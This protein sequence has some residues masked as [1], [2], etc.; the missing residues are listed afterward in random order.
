[1]SKKQTAWLLGGGLK[2]AVRMIT[3]AQYISAEELF[4]QLKSGGEVRDPASAYA[5]VVWAYRCVNLRALIIGNLPWRIVDQRG[6]EVEGWPLAQELDDLL[7]RV[8]F[9]LCLWGASYLLKQNDGLALKGLRWQNPLTMRPLI[10]ARGGLI[11]FEQRLREEGGA[12]T[13]AR[14][15]P[16]Q[17]IYHR[18]ENPA[19]D[20]GPGVSPLQVALSAAGL[21][22]NANVYAEKFFEHGAIPAVVLTTEEDL[23]EGDREEARN[24]WRRT[25]GG[26]KKSWETGIFGRGLKPMVV[27]S[28]VK[29]LVLSSLYQ[30]MRSQICVAF[31][32]PQTLLEDAA[33]FA[34]AREHKLELYQETIFP[35]GRLI[36]KGLNRQLFDALGLTFE[37]AEEQVEAVQ[38]DEATKA[39]AI[40]GLYDKGIITLNE[41]RE[42]LGYEP[43]AE[44]EQEAK[45]EPPPA[46]E[47]SVE[48]EADAAPLPKAAYQELARW[49]R[50]AARGEGHFVSDV[51]PAWL[52]SAIRARLLHPLL[53]DH[54]IEPALRRFDAEGARKK[55]TKKVAAALSSH[56]DD[57]ILGALGGAMP[58]AALG[59]LGVSLT[60]T[61]TEGLLMI[62]LDLLLE[63]ATETGVGID[64]DKE[65]IDAAK[66]AADY[67]YEQVKDVVDTERRLLQ[68]VISR[69]TDG[70]IDQEA[71]ELLL[72]PSFGEVRAALIATSEATRAM[73]HAT[74]QYKEEL[75][76]RGPSPVVR[77]LT[78]EDEKVCDLCGP[79]D[80]LPEEKWRDQYPD[81]PPAHPGCRCRTVVELKR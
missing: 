66:W 56:A 38:Q 48:E 29:D 6:N 62:A 49:R 71:A 17:V 75:R 26:V 16:G 73:S 1:M 65:M 64:Y 81:G 41:A 33:N 13:V 27:G 18:L 9:A 54:A 45:E 8:E 40:M 78:E 50:K 24:W 34:T 58:E 69:L 10:E 55:L 68:D 21:A 70:Q 3:E 7:G 12:E 23:L 19:D 51:I 53:R 42:Q 22:R 39:T 20:L 43:L 60:S 63:L 5:A 46:E 2:R 61:L 80:H 79:L 28:P 77:W 4:A 11:G 25:F 57:V 14:F 67:S 76:E 32:I 74:D 47:E 15:R 37:F 31:G 52:R 59:K 35:E 30:E 36:A 44:E 72:R